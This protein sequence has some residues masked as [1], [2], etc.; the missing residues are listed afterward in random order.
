MSVN[1]L[2]ALAAEARPLIDAF[3][4]TRRAGSPFVYYAND[5]DDGGPLNQIRLVQSGVGKVNAA[6]ATAWLAAQNQPSTAPW[7]N[8]GIAGHRT[9]P[10]GSI[11]RANKITDAATAKH[12]YPADVLKIPSVQ[13]RFVGDRVV[14]VDDVENDYAEN[15][16]YDMEASG[17]VAAA[18]R[19]TSSE[20]VQSLKVISDGPDHTVAHITERTVSESIAGAVDVIRAL[21]SAMTTLHERLPRP[22]DIDASAWL[23]RWRFSVTQQHRLAQALHS[24]A[25][26]YPERRHRLFEEM[27]VRF[28]RS[29][30][31]N[32]V[33]EAI[34]SRL[35]VEFELSL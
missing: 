15:A 31:A 2:V 22:V 7:L 6:A 32:R 18:S 14:T 28:E 11:V 30:S 3:S 34:E 8:I 27:S 13:R 23:N 17:F 10:I 26:R 29:A 33:I 24:H 5:S 1:I 20:L 25:L 21:V 9:L 19:F 35:A 4:L 16:A 12:Y